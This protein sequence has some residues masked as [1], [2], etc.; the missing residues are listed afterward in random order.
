MIATLGQ[1][2][3]IYTGRT[4]YSVGT[5]KLYAPAGATGYDT[6]NW[7]SVLLDSIKCGF[8]LKGVAA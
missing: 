4:S 6:G 1:N 7:A 3:T 8:T 2:S 5:N